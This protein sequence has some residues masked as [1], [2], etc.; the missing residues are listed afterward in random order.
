MYLSEINK[1]GINP[2]QNID[3]YNMHLKRELKKIL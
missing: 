3:E 1:L 2:N